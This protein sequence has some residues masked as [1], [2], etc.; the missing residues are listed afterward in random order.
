VAEQVG[1]DLEALS[2]AGWIVKLRSRP[3]GSEI[4]PESLSDERPSG[5]WS[6]W[7]CWPN[8]RHGEARRKHMQTYDRVATLED[9]VKWCQAQAKGWELLPEPLTEEEIQARLAAEYGPPE[10][11]PEPEPPAELDEI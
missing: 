4:D 9:A 7:M 6:V 8:S 1:T 5:T 11:E 3:M 10:P 2:A